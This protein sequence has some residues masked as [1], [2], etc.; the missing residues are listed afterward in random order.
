MAM[1]RFKFLLSVC[2]LLPAL[3]GV[4]SLFPL[5]VVNGQSG[6]IAPTGVGASDGSY[7]NKIGIWWDTMRGATRYQVFRNTSNDA[8]AA[9]SIGT[10]VEATFFD[11]TAVAGQNYFYW[12][13][14]ENTNAAS[15][16]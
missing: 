10:T 16:L 9:V 4:F 15:V 5:P 12:V 13:R 14:S 11:T 2:F 1:R 3:A 7:N 8:A 6:L